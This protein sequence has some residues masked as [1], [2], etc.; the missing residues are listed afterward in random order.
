MRGEG[1]TERLGGV[2]LVDASPRPCG[3]HHSLNGL[4]VEM[5]ALPTAGKQPAIGRRQRRVPPHLAPGDVRQHD[6][7]VPA[8]LALAHVTASAL[9]IEA[10]RAELHKGVDRLS[11]EVSNRQAELFPLIEPLRA[12]PTSG[13]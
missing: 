3:R 7:P 9:R 1:V 5:P 13:A 11:S 2:P 6:V 4:G 10:R 8:S 12:P